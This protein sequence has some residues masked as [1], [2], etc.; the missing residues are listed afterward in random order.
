MKRFL[1][2]LLLLFFLLVA[3]HTGSAQTPFDD[4]QSNPAV[5]DIEAVYEKGIMIGT[6]AD[7][8]SRMPLLTRHSLLCV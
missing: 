6:T 8:F 3:P 1:L 4:I 7:K 5:A 2:L